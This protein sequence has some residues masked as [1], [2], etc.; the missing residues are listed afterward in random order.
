MSKQGG[1]SEQLGE[2][3]WLAEGEG[4][5]ILER[6]S[7]LVIYPRSLA[8]DRQSLFFLGRLSGPGHPGGARAP[9]TAQKLGILSRGSEPGFALPIAKVTL[10]GATYCLA[11]GDADHAN[12]AA[13]R[14]RLPFLA[15]QPVGVRKSVGLGDRIGL[16]TPGH[17]RALR[18][19]E[20]VF[21]I[22]AQQSIREME[23]SARTPAEVMDGATW[24]VFQEGWRGGYG[25]DAD[26]QKN[27]ADIDSCLAQGFITYTI[28][29]RD[30]VDNAADSDALPTLEAKFVVL[31]WDRLQTTAEATRQAYL[32]HTWSLGGGESLA[33]SEEQ[34]LRA[35][36]KY[37]RALAH[38]AGLYAYLQRAAAGRPYELEVS[39]DETDTPTRPEEHLY[40]A[41]ELR[42]M[43][44]QWVSLAPRYIG[45]F[46]KGVDYIGDLG[47][48]E[49]EFRRHVAIAKMLG[50]YKLSLHSGSDKFSIYPIAA[51]LAGE[52]VHLK[53]AG[54]WYLE[55]LRAVATVDPGLFRQILRGAIDH[56]QTNRESYYVS[57]RPEKVPQPEGL[58]DGEL[59]GVLDQFD[60][61]QALH[62]AFATVLGG[63]DEQGQWL[64]R[65]RLFEALRDCEEM[66]YT[67]VEAHALRHLRPFTS[68]G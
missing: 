3:S 63:R 56:Y 47:I 27:E 8:P 18:R 1:K 38:I 6:A 31:P 17:V 24:G 28:D 10:N 13:L 45:R 9:G 12:A 62:V 57:A 54:T 50:P 23:R 60:A 34:M 53:T 66:H 46:E 21:P 26:H 42:R 4:I 41:S 59:A 52:L 65:Q 29:P 67:A 19:I 39:V 43:G 51:R 20:G 68:Q 64:Y 22:L 35:A 61:R 25:A 33:L 7:G 2:W 32:G 49:G 40:L 48:F 44:V 5:G 36:C 37:G 58:A 14:A 15:P 16:A 11:T 30:H 55:A